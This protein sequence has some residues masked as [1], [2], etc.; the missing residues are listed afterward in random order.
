MQSSKPKSSYR[1][2][3]INA[4][5]LFV[6]FAIALLIAT[7]ALVRRVNTYE[8]TKQ[9]LLFSVSKEKIEISNSVTG[10]V[11]QVAVNI[12]QHVTKGDLLV[13][14]SDDSRAQKLNSLSEVSEENLSAKTEFELLKARASEYEIKAPRDGVVYQIHAAEGSFLNSSSPVLTLFADSN[15]KLVG[16]ITPAQYA[17]IQKNKDLDV[18]AN[19]FEQIYKVSFQGV[20][21]VLPGTQYEESKYEVQFRFANADDGA[22]FI[23]GE[24][25]EVVSHAEDEQAL[26]PSTRIANF[27]NKILSRY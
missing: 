15:V 12:G 14:L 26:R 13:R 18:Y 8:V 5:Y 1:N 22:A 25:L 2:F 10:R 17:E 24:S 6:V 19:R 11:D 20:G 3:F 21:R 9:P 16:N 7:Q 23:E 4:L 27:W